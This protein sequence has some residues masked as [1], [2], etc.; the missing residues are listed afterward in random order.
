MS[1]ILLGAKGQMGSLVNS[2]WSS[3]YPHD[4]IISPEHSSQLAQMAPAH[5]L[6]DFSHASAISDVLAYG[7]KTMTP[8]LIATTGHSDSEKKDIIKASHRLPIF[9][10]GN[11][12]LGIV[13]VRRLA[14][15]A[16]KLLGEGCD[17]EVIEKHH[18]LK[19]DAPSG[20]AYMLLEAVKEN[21]PELFYV[22]GRQG[23]SPRQRNEV[24][25]H[26]IRG[27]SIIGEHTLLFA[28]DQESIELTHKGESKQI[29]ALG[30]LNAADFLKKQSHGLYTMDDLV[31][32]DL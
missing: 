25:V 3:R 27:G 29:Y 24:G 12:S 10:S 6:I 9:Y 2:L 23:H 4:E 15:Y 17:I 32:G 14:A 1:L 18:H 16:S 13:I 30:A 28:L 8:L 26:A 31:K 22:H 5:V 21:R 7:L 19:Q 20:T 11:L